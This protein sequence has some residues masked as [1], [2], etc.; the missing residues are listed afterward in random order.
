MAETG[1]SGT[2]LMRSLGRTAAVYAP[3]SGL[4]QPSVTVGERVT[5]GQ[6]AGRIFFPDS[7][8]REVCDTHPGWL[9]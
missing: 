8:M 9:L 4:F 2:R 3:E 7:P 1:P 6:E 5:A